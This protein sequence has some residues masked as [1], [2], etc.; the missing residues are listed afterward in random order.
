MPRDATDLAS[1]LTDPSLLACKAYV[2]GEW[3]DA[4]DGA[5]VD[6]T[7]PARGDVI[8]S[9]ADL[10]RA[11]TARAVAAAEEAMEDWRAL[12]AKARAQVL[13][14]WFDLMMEAQE[15]LAVI[16]TTEQG[17]PLAEARGEVA[18]GARSNG[19]QTHC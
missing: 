4:D 9:V 2:A 1:L 11:E 6:V 19:L 10:G 5:T 8:C 14:R 17:K 7:N 18:Y 15:D 16:L 13:R 12:T 3:I